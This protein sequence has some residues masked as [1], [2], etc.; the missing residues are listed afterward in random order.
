MVTSAWPTAPYQLEIGLI[1][2]QCGQL[3]GEGRFIEPVDL[4]VGGL[5]H[6]VAV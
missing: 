4:D 2:D 3:S 5:W 6:G 1:R